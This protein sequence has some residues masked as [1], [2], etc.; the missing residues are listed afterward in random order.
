MRKIIFAMLI[1]ALVAMSCRKEQVYE[2]VYDENVNPIEQ[3]ERALASATESG[4]FVICQV[5]GNWCP[6]CLRFAHFVTT[7]TAITRVIDENYVYIHVNYNPRNADDERNFEAREAL[8][9]LDNPSRFGYPVLVVLDGEGN[10]LHFQDT[11]LL[12]SGEGYD[13]DKVLRFFS[14][15]TPAEVAKARQ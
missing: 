10:V 9:R 12:E 11:A 7:D 5:G 3:I 4:K 15:W 13:R 2:Q 14:S 6:W 1:T 8:R